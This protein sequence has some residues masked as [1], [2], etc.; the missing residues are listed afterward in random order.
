MLGCFLVLITITAAITSLVAFSL[1][2][3]R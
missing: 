1:A 3:V 2:L